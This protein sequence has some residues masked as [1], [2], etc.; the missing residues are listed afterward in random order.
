MLIAS[1]I[2]RNTM[3]L[4]TKKTKIIEPA[5][6]KRVSNTDASRR[7]MY[8]AFGLVDRVVKNTDGTFSVPSQSTDSKMYEISM[9]TTERYV[10]TCPDFQYREIQSCKHIEAV[11]LYKSEGAKEAVAMARWT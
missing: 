11:K 6:T 3:Q 7:R 10:C 9:L 5:P 2:D 4:I 8:K 1:E